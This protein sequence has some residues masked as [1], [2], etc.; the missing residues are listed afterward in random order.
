ML[1]RISLFDFFV[2]NDMLTMSSIVA[3][4]FACA[5]GYN[6]QCLKQESWDERVAKSS[7]LSSVT[8]QYALRLGNA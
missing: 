2:S 1:S 3:C 8:N 7:V 5:R 6:D 4:H